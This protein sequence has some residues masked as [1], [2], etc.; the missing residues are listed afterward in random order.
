MIVGAQL[1]FLLPMRMMEEEFLMDEER[2][3]VQ[4]CIYLHCIVHSV[5]QTIIILL[6]LCDYIA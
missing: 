6:L 2:V 1:Q 3:P 5:I 4:V